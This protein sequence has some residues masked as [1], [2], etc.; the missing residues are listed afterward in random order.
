MRS[1]ILITLFFIIIFLI[2][3]F[4]VKAADPI[5]YTRLAIVPF[6]NLTG[7]KDKNW[8]GEG[9]SE[10]VA[11]EL[12][13]IKGLI[14]IERSQLAKAV[15]E[16]K[17]SQSGLSDEKTAVKIGKLTSAKYLVIG[18]YQMVEGDIL[19]NARLIEVESGGIKQ[20]ARVKGDFKKIFD[21]QDKLARS[22]LTWIDVTPGEIELNK[23]KSST[24]Q[25]VSI[26]EFL[27]RAREAYYAGRTD[28][29]EGWINK[30]LAVDP[31]QPEAV[32][33]QG[34]IQELRG[35]NRA[36]LATFTSAAEK[37]QKR[38]DQKT[39]SQGLGNI[40]GVFHTLGQND[41]AIHKFQQSLNVS[42]AIGYEKGTAYALNGMGRIYHA[43]GRYDL[44]LRY[45][46]ESLEISEKIGEERYTSAVLAN[47][48]AV[49][50]SQEKSD[51]ALANYRRSLG[52]AK[53]IGATRVVAFVHSSI[54]NI[55]AQQHRFSQALAELNE[56]LEIYRTTGDQSGAGWALKHLGLVF[57]NQRRLEEALSYY[58]QSLE[59]ARRIGEERLAALDVDNIGRVY[60]ATG[61]Y[62]AARNAYREAIE[63]YE[64]IGNLQ[65]AAAARGL[66]NGLPR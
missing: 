4:P 61:R 38:N 56:S 3:S 40:A 10:S 34:D 14:L 46:K 41:E 23:M 29:A 8:L 20:A 7:D 12:G 55:Y 65:A 21:L 25:D 62:E 42:R 22:T 57:Y 33:L 24:V 36:A 9:I 5:T 48:G 27:S 6:K 15:D 54:G 35:Q 31:F 30:V 18:S 26:L 59:I 39:Y 37:S 51:E 47:I 45:M 66:M 52:T 50:S 60:H 53:K 11:T 43:Q 2:C 1:K 49:Y 19:L 28:E 17:L 63:L 58:N 64:K 13:T 32:M 44:A 16:L